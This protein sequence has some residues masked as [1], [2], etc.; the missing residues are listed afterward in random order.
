LQCLGTL[1]KKANFFLKFE[2][3]KIWRHPEKNVQIGCYSS[4]CRLLRV[5][6]KTRQQLNQQGP[7]YKRSAKKIYKEAHACC[8][9]PSLSFIASAPSLLVQTWWCCV[10]D[11][12]MSSGCWL[13][14][15][16]EEWCQRLCNSHPS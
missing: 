2:F 7:L 10:K 4:W 3:A 16:L 6:L 13:V 8:T 14:T 1:V 5:L 12:F 11:D 9:G 15:A